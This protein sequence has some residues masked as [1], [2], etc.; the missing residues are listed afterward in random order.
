VLEHVDFTAADPAA[1]GAV[2]RRTLRAHGFD[3]AWE[4]AVVDMVARVV[5]TP[6][7]ATGAVRLDRVSLAAR[8][9]ELEFHTPIGG[10]DGRRLG[11]LL[12]DH[13]LGTAPIREAVAQIRVEAVA[14]FMKGFIDLVCEC[15]G[16][17]WVVDY[18]SNWL[19]DR[20][21]DYASE[22]LVP[23]IAGEA[24]WLQYLIY[25]VVVH[26]WLRRRLPAYDYDRHMGGVRYLFL[27]GMH[28]DRGTATGVYQDR[29]S[30][31]LVEALDAFL[32]PPEPA[33]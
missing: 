32:T 29:P 14:G 18:K 10:L 16:R 3:V 26:R 9:N 5:A 27:R 7:D 21:D 1:W 20:L 11:R 17:Y 4:P 13:E 8:V 25:T 19:G 28:P 2:A 22:R 33:R 23:V 15:D 30:R 24:Y 31:H 12:L 6:L